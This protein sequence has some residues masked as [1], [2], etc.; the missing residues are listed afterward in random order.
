MC[1]TETKSKFVCVC[2]CAYVCVCYIVCVIVSKR[3]REREKRGD[4]LKRYENYCF[5]GSKFFFEVR[6]EGEII[7]PQNTLKIHFQSDW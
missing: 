7:F 3:E 6:S 4:V 1:E 2:V 5:R